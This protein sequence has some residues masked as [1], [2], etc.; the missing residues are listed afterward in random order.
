MAKRPNPATA[1]LRLAAAI[2]DRREERGLTQQKVA[3]KADMSVRHY[4]K[5]E[6]GEVDVRYT[7]LVAV[8]TALGSRIAD[9]TG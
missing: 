3:E 2:R 9:L 8:A 6:T 7:S 5:I 4:Q 1:V